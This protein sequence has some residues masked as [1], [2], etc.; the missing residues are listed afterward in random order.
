MIFGVNS[1]QTVALSLETE[2]H[3]EALCRAQRDL[4]VRSMSRH[5]HFR[6]VIAHFLVRDGSAMPF[7]APKYL[8][9][10][11]ALDLKGRD[12]QALLEIW[13]YFLKCLAEGN[14]VL[15]F[16]ADDVDSCVKSILSSGKSVNDF[17]SPISPNCSQRCVVSY[18]VSFYSFLYSGHHNFNLHRRAPQVPTVFATFFA[19]PTIT[20]HRPAR[21][22]MESQSR[23]IIQLPVSYKSSQ[24]RQGMAFYN[25]CCS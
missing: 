6:Y 1:Y 18:K 21:E 25:S 19:V 5:F 11:L 22:R 3:R 10:A 12:L 8:S 4:Q 13:E 17:L 16:E 15:W 24:R 2:I 7:W 14:L 20:F 23:F 9:Q